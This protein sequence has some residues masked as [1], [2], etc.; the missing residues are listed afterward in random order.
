LVVG[1][2]IA[3]TSFFSKVKH[4]FLISVFVVFLSFLTVLISIV[5]LLIIL[6]RVVLI[7]IVYSLL[8]FV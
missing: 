3:R 7:I 6:L 8:H 1:T 4:F 2:S 5:V